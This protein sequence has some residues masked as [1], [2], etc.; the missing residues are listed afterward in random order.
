M[1]KLK[2]LTMSTARAIED[3]IGKCENPEC[4]VRRNLNVHHIDW[5]RKNN[6]YGNLIVFCDECHRKKPHFG[7]M[8]KTIQRKIVRNRP[9]KIKEGIK[10]ILTKADERQRG[11]IS[12]QEYDREV[13]AVYERLGKKGRFTEGE[14]I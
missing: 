14:T 10:T 11:V 5:E 1:A 4:G 3:C 6:T 12:E 7:P 2:E 9:P 13:E 8:S